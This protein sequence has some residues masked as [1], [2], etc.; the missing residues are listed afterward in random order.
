MIDVQGQLPWVEI[1]DVPWA[2]APILRHS[3]GTRH[4]RI[5]MARW[6]RVRFALFWVYCFRVSLCRVVRV[7]CRIVGLSD[8]GLLWKWVSAAFGKVLDQAGHKS[9]TQVPQPPRVR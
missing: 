7:G 1:V 4:R 5:I 3:V 8:V 2:R 6:A 9:P